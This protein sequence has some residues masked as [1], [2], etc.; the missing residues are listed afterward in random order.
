ME[1]SKVERPCLLS[2]KR[3]DI[4]TEK[5]PPKEQERKKWDRFMEAARDLSR[6]KQLR[7]EKNDG[8][9]IVPLAKDQAER[10]T[11]RLFVPLWTGT[12]NDMY[13]AARPGAYIPCGEGHFFSTPILQLVNKKKLLAQKAVGDGGW[14]YQMES[15]GFKV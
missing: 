3:D 6:K 9:N 15:I 14:R 7:L 10:G 1:I 8:R 12:V 11:E 13:L 2:T 4:Q 5:N